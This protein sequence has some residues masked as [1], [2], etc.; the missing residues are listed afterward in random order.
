MGFVSYS[1]AGKNERWVRVAAENSVSGEGTWPGM[2]DAIRE[3]VR[4]A[5]RQDGAFADRSQESFNL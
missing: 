2:N 5:S 3:S 1:L 4:R